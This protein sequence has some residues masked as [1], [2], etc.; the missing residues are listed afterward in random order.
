MPSRKKAQGQARKAKQAPKYGSPSCDHFHSSNV[1]TRE[2]HNECYKLLEMYEENV[3]DL[4]RN[5]I[6][7]IER[8]IVIAAQRTSEKYHVWDNSRKQLFRKVILSKMTG[9]ILRDANRAPTL[10]EYDAIPSIL[11]YLELFVIIE[12]FDKNKV[13]VPDLND[14]VVSRVIVESQ[15]ML[16]DIRCTRDIVRFVDKR[17]SC[18]CLKSIYNELKKTTTRQNVCHNCNQMK[19]HKDIKACSK[20]NTVL[21]CSRECQLAHWPEHKDGCKRVRELFVKCSMDREKQNKQ[22]VVLS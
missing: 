16:N 14:E 15:R 18:D 1:Y 13:N 7:H 3:Y 20:C 22:K 17:N 10:A 6:D 21:Y 9:R 12:V 4:F 19:H 2:D 5:N 11:D 8:R